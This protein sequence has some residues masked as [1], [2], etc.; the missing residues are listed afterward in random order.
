VGREGKVCVST[1]GKV[2]SAGWKRLRVRGAACGG[3][4][5]AL[6]AL[7]QVGRRGHC[8]PPPSTTRKTARIV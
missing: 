5:T 7:L 8:L 4:M 1:T 3:G 2:Q 6:S